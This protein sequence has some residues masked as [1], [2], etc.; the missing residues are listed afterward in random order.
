MRAKIQII[1][2]QN[3]KIR[4][5]RFE[6]IAYEAV[7]APGNKSFSGTFAYGLYIVRY[8][9]EGAVIYYEISDNERA[10][11]TA[12]AAVAAAT[13][14]ACI[15]VV[16]AIGGSLGASSKIRTKTVSDYI[17]IPGVT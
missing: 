17:I 13:A 3:S 4:D 9:S 7:P 5:K 12:N 1:R 14:T 6:G 11:Q 10:Q 8:R 16:G 15:Y 2:Y